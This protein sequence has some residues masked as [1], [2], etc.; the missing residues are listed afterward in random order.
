MTNPTTIVG[1]VL[2]PAQRHSRSTRYPPAAL[3]R[4][5]RMAKGTRVRRLVLDYD[6]KLNK[7]SDTYDH[8]SNMLFDT[9]YHK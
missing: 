9:V 2:P 7:F 4:R 6:R 8:V 3:L 1:P 5:K